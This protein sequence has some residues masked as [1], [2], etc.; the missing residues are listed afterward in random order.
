MEQL[1]ES[2]A[3]ELIGNGIALNCLDPGWVLTRP[4]DD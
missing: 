3:E 1:T 4:N 2:M